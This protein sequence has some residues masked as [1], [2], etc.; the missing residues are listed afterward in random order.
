MLKA[1]GLDLVTTRGHYMMD[2][3]VIYAT[4]RSSS[5]DDWKICLEVVLERKQKGDL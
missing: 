4:A 5:C 1:D 2:N 3:V